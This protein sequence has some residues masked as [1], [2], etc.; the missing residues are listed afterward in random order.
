MISQHSRPPGSSPSCTQCPNLRS[1]S[2]ETELALAE[3]TMQSSFNGGEP[4]EER[5]NVIVDGGV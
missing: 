1:V 5:P 4:E 2:S 3:M